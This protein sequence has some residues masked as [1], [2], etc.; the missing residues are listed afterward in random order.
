MVIV[1]RA[2]TVYAA[3][4]KRKRKAA[5]AEAIPDNAWVWHIYRGTPDDAVGGRILQAL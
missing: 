4:K 2:P 5:V 3:V 1:F